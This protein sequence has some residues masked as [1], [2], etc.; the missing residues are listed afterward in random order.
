M[1]FDAVFQDGVFMPKQPIE[2]PNG[3]EVRVAIQTQLG[4]NDSLASV[5]GTCDGPASGDAADAHDN[6]IY[7]ESDR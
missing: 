4:A 2:L 6:Y 5:I 7:G 3:T 1:Q